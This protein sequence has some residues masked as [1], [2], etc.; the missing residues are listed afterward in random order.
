MREMSDYDTL[1]GGSTFSDQSISKSSLKS[2]RM[3]YHGI[4]VVARS[5]RNNHYDILAGASSPS[6]TVTIT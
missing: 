6:I 4:L 2:E 1:A 3:S 5:P